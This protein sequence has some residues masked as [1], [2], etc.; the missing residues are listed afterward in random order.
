[1]EKTLE[2]HLQELREQIV[3]EIEA[4][5][6]NAVISNEYNFNDTAVRAKT[7]LIAAD[8]ARGKND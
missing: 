3:L 8:I 5:S 6:I 2:I 4:A 7:F 1:M